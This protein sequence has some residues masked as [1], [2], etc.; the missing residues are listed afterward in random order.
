MILLCNEA[1]TGM[2][3]AA[4]MMMVQS[5]SNSHAGW[6]PLEM[7]PTNLMQCNTIQDIAI[8]YDA[9]QSDAIKCN[10]ICNMIKCNEPKALRCCL[11]L[12]M[13]PTNLMQ[14]NTR[15]CHKI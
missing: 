5:G 9:I 6:L 4:G 7:L 8:K 3:V 10:A 13:L 11:P 15:Y 14:C 1:C 2:P 12:E